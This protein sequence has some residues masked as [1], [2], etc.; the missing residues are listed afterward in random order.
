MF[1]QRISE[2]VEDIRVEGKKSIEFAIIF[3]TEGEIALID[4]YIIGKYISNNYNAHMEQYYK[5]ISLNNIVKHVVNGNDKSKKDFLILS[6]KI[7]NNTLNSIYCDIKFKK[8]MLQEH[9]DKYNL[10]HC[11]GDDCALVVA[12]I[13]IME[14]ICRYLRINSNILEEAINYIGQKKNSQNI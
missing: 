12:V 3:N 11:V 1:N 2:L 6:Y 9:V 10:K 14:D 13:L 7:L 8:D 5:E 4:S